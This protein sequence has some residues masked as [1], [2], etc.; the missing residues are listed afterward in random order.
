MI[1]STSESHKRK[2]KGEKLQYEVLDLLLEVFHELQDE[3]TSC[4]MC[5]HGEDIKFSDIARAI[6]PISIECKTSIK[7]Y[8]KAYH[9]IGQAQHQT[10][11]LGR[12]EDDITPVAFVN[13]EAKPIL[14]VLYAIDYLK[15]QRE[16]YLLRQ[17][18][19]RLTNEKPINQQSNEDE[20]CEEPSIQEK[21]KVISCA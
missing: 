10:R 13:E 15:L 4:H 18:I 3:I 11:K 5:S 12:A 2:L 9:D 20:T 1:K 17:Q 7:G 8:S 21:F 19:R 6:L 16:N 14:V